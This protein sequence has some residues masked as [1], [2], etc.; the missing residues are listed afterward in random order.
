V[1]GLRVLYNA[2][3]G[4]CAGNVNDN[5]GHDGGKGKGK[6]KGKMSSSQ[7]LVKRKPASAAVKDAD[8]LPS[9]D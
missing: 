3:M 2:I 7:P 6:G 1:R 4:K 8:R 5:R 9:C